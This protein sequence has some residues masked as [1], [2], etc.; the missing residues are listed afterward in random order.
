ML[1]ALTLVAAGCGGGDQRTARDPSRGAPVDAAVRAHADEL[2]DAGRDAFRFDT[3]GDQVFWGDTLRLHDAVAGAANGGVG[4]GLSPR[5]ALQLGLKVDAEALPPELRDA[6]A[7][8][9]V[10]LDS[11]ATT[12]GLLQLDSVV[13]VTGFF[14]ES[15]RLTSIGIQCALCHSTVDDSLAPGIGRR[16]DGWA[17]RDLD[18]GAIIAFAP[19]VSVLGSLLGVD[20]E[21]VRSVLRSW[22]PGKFDAALLLDGKAF[23]PDG[24][25]AATLIPPAYGLGGVNL[26]TWTGWGSV[27]HW[28]ALVATLE[29]QGQGTFYDP[30]LDDAERF[31]IAA[32]T[33][34]GHV[35]SDPDLVTPTLA[36]LQFYQLALPVPSPAPGSF[37]PQAAARGARLFAGAARCATCHVPPLFTEPGWN[38]HR[39]EEIGIDD[40]QAG[41]SPDGRY[42]TAPLR[43]LSAHAH[44]G[45]YHDGRF[46]T[47]AAVVDHYDGVFG[48]GLADG[49]RA[50]L[51]EYLKSL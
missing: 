19:D 11:P 14:D 12:L 34:A 13:G 33:G 22:G 45:F 18:V 10:D 2:L 23:R 29:M 27:S 3:L 7:A 30:R 20:D 48:L 5:G 50:D 35:H 25:P 26:H 24:T 28:N 15:R 46:P 44:G 32:R 41:R 8:G 39:P 21:T 43:G 40:F 36:A 16:L 49:D 47:L 38:L 6:L 37:D 31:P 42:R 1:F 4:P 51:V 9:E 17:N